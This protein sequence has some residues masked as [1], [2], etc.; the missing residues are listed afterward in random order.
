MDK[1]KE[2]GDKF[3]KDLKQMVTDLQTNIDD[4]G[5]YY[6]NDFENMFPQCNEIR[7]AE[8]AYSV[9]INDLTARNINEFE[10]LN[11][12]NENIYPSAISALNDDE[13]IIGINMPTIEKICYSLKI[14]RTLTSF[15]NYL[16]TNDYHIV[17]DLK[18]D[19]WSY[20]DQQ[21]FN[22][23]GFILRPNNCLFHTN[24]R[25]NENVFENQM[26][27]PTSEKNNGVAYPWILTKFY[28]LS[29]ANNRDE[30]I[31]EFSSDVISDKVSLEIAT[32]FYYPLLNR[33]RIIDDAIS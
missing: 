10:I 2:Y 24:R 5:I 8:G 28:Y 18:N 30:F 29:V 25:W 33:N 26:K 12:E 32:D 4:V 16:L 31:E 15:S 19:E 7:S 27:F 23:K 11:I 3:Q 22:V 20:S 14:E 21:I 1:T 13:I 9:P 17:L 6:G